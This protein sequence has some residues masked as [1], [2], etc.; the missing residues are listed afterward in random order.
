MR[1]ALDAI[2]TYWTLQRKNDDESLWSVEKI[3]NSELKNSLKATL[4]DKKETFQT[5][6]NEKP[7][8]QQ[9]IWTE[10]TEQKFCFSFAQ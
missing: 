8:C 4:E 7:N 5:F 10:T 6:N 1:W 9:E 3:V 2:E